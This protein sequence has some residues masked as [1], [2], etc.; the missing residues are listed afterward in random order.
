MFCH[1]LLPL[2]D[3]H[4][5]GEGTDINTMID[6]GRVPT[7]PLADR[8]PAGAAACLGILG[9]AADQLGGAPAKILG[10]S[11]TVRPMRRPA[12]SDRCSYGL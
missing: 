11:R 5:V 3:T 12:D 8:A 2:A 6:R 9:C 7:D 10:R 4:T 1:R